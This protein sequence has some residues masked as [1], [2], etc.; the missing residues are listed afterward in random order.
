MRKLDS[1]LK[2]FHQ[3]TMNQSSASRFTLLTSI[4]YRPSGI[5]L[6]HSLLRNIRPSGI[7]HFETS[8]RKIFR[9]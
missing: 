8:G 3:P 5:R 2:G 4:N 1:G 6:R 7:R 9:P